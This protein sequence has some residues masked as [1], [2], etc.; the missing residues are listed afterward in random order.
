MIVDSSALA[1]IF[2][3]EDEGLEALQIIKRERSYT[4]G[5]GIKEVLN[6]AWKRRSLL[7]DDGLRLVLQAVM[8][9]IDAK[10][11]ELL[12]QKPFLER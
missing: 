10:L 1:A 9:A 5:L 4:L 8:K 6:T 7:G 12:D 2:L 3:H 11:I